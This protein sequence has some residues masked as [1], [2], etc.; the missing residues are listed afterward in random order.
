M[1]EPI[2]LFARRYR[3]NIHRRYNLLLFASDPAVI[4]TLLPLLLVAAYFV[5]VL[6][7]RRRKAQWDLQEQATEHETSNPDETADETS[8]EHS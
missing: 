3:A 5:T 4:F 6:R 1:G 2:T 7:A 8:H